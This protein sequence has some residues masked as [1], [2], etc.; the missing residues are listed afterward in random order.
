[1]YLVVVLLAWY[2]FIL[3]RN[4]HESERRSLQI[5]AEA[6]A[7]DQVRISI[8]VLGVDP[9]SSQ[10]TAR[11]GFRLSGSIAQDEITPAVD[12]KLFLNSVQGPQ[13]FG[14][15]RGERVN[16]I[17][18][19]FSTDGDVNAYPLD[20]HQAHIQL[21]MTKPSPQ[22]VKAQPAKV[23]VEPDAEP[24]KKPG[25]DHGKKP[26]K[27][28]EAKPAEKQVQ[29]ESA[30]TFTD[31][32]VGA[33]AMQRSETVA[34]SPALSASIPG[35]KFEGN[36]VAARRDGPTTVE[37]RIRRAD[38]VIAISF[39]VMGLM[40]SLAW[41][42]FLMALRA[43]TSEDVPTLMPLSLAVTLLFGLPALRDIQPGVPPVGAF[44]D[45][46]VF[47]WAE[48]MVALSAVFVMWAWLRGHRSKKHGA[49]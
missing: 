46:V 38:Q 26:E 1:V 19:V 39:F 28:P 47:L 14:F 42:L 11:L 24:E 36:L 21:L 5:Q 35:V 37:L 25:R 49:E 16:A 32:I 48:M 27:K 8:R 20:R 40:A 7:A 18:A 23:A 30:S 12:L 17:V 43:I 15:P 41:S 45:Y 31:V 3:F 6:K 34:I 13:E 2:G 29:P 9:N 10:L 4:L 44:W 33:T 22:P